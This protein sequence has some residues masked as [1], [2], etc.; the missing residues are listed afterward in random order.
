VDNLWSPWKNQF[1]SDNDGMM[2]AAANEQGVHMAVNSS[3]NGTVSPF[4]IPSD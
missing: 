1:S 4:S 2:G 3:D